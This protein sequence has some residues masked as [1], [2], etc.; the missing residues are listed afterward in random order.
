MKNPTLLKNSNHGIAILASAC[1]SLLTPLTG[2]ASDDERPWTLSGSGDLRALTALVKSNAALVS[3][4]DRYGKYLLHHAAAAGQVEIVKFLLADGA[5]IMGRDN[6]G[7]TPLHHAVNNHYAGMTELLIAHGA[8]V[9]EPNLMSWTPLH[10]AV[11]NGDK[12][13]VNALIDAG[14]DVNAKTS[15]DLTP[16]NLAVDNG[17]RDIVDRLVVAMGDRLQQAQTP[18][19]AISAPTRETSR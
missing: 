12:V 19:L 10:L 11:L 2:R 5:D 16:Y 7:W 13:M 8:K 14:A 6:R 18:M 1:L 4:Q 9:N 17:K 3:A 15:R